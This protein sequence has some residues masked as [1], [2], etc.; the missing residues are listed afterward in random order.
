MQLLL[1]LQYINQ[2]LHLIRNQREQNL[3]NAK[4]NLLRK[5]TE[6]AADPNSKG[7]GE[8]DSWCQRAGGTNASYRADVVSKLKSVE[9]LEET[10]FN[11]ASFKA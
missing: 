1:E 5:I 10:R 7:F 3:E 4:D 11:A 9:I 8:M 6:L 2:S